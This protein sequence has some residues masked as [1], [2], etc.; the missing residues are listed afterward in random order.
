MSSYRVILRDAYVISPCRKSGQGR[1]GTRYHPASI[2]QK[3]REP[4]C[5]ASSSAPALASA[6][7]DTRR[8]IFTGAFRQ[9]FLACSSLGGV[10]SSNAFIRLPVGYRETRPRV[11]PPSEIFSFHLRQEPGFLTLGTRERNGEVA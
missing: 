10:P 3:T 4:A 5:V 2:Q 8:R 9:A 6:S 7:A 11:K 1:L